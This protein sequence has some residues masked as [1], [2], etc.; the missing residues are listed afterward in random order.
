VFCRLH[1]QKAKRD[2]AKKAKYQPKLA[3]IPEGPDE[4]DPE[5]DG[6]KIAGWLR[7]EMKK[8]SRFSS[9]LLHSQ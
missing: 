8:I 1:K 2:A 6:N 7:E 9:A 5:Y 3:T 4:I